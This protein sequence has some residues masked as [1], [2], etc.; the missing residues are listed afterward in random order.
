[1]RRS[2]IFYVVTF[3]LGAVVL[4]NHSQAASLEYAYLIQG[5]PAN[6]AVI[7]RYGSLENKPYYSCSLDTFNCTN[8]GTTAPAVTALAS[9]NTETVTTSDPFDVLAGIERV[10][11]R[12]VSPD[13]KWVYYYQYSTP[14]D[15]NSHF[16]L[17]DTKTKGT[18]ETTEN[19]SK[20]WDL[21]TEENRLFSV[22]PD[23]KTLVY[24]DNRDGAN[25]LYQVNL[26]RPSKNMMLGT[27]ITKL[28]YTV[29][30]FVFLDSHTILFMANRENP[31]IWNLYR[32]NLTTGDIIQVAGNTSYGDAMIKLG[33]NVTFLQ[34]KGNA[35]VPVVYN[36]ISRTV[37]QFNLPQTSGIEAV[38]NPYQLVQYGDVWG[39]LLKPITVSTTAAK[40]PDEASPLI[41]WLH[42]GPYRDIGPTIQSYLSYGVYD[43]SLEE[44]RRNGAVVLKIDYTGSYGHGKA[45]AEG[46]K[47]EAGVADVA[48]VVT[49]LKGVKKTLGSNYPIS[50][51]YV[52]GN[53]YGG[54][55]ALKSIVAHPSLFNGAYSINGVTDWPTLL[56]S[57]QTSIFNVYFG[58]LPTLANSKYYA[59]AD[60]IDSVSSLTTANK[61]MLVQAQSDTTIDPA[62]ADF[63]DQQLIA[64]GK[65]VQE[66]KIPNE[67]HVFYLDSSIQTI[68]NSLITF[69][70]LTPNDP[71]RCD[72]N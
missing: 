50:G 66:I 34:M 33:N 69:V 72:Y 21:L 10:S 48:D 49:A 19:N 26:A 27:R 46:L 17:Y 57:L 28:S 47:D 39:V 42:G 55:L 20:D 2:Y 63:L 31:E 53:S 65:N 32:Y 60:I 41:I 8:E 11:Y 15:I 5:D 6:N 61:I 70:G 45:F 62:Q 22:S 44:A 30:D 36:Y 16:I 4:P 1:M 23:S 12:G 59:Q 51:V 18:S 38:N 35:V 37:T 24:L 13:G 71:A 40:L 14:S 43:W 9:T 3:I 58:G 64:K 54:Y 56:N 25:A 52:V 7:L 67:D 68:C 29:A